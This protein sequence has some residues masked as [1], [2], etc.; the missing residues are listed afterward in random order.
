MK[1]LSFFAGAL[2]ISLSIIGGSYIIRTSPV[3][4]PQ[5]AI[6]PTS[7]PNADTKAVLTLPE[8]AAFLN[9]QEDQ[10]RIMVETEEKW[11]KESKDA[12]PDIIPFFKIREEFFFSRTALEKWAEQS[13]NEH[14]RYNRDEDVV[15]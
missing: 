1:N 2:L 11:I 13:A 10:L 3:P 6:Q 9:L 8:A 7:L 14:R 5:P 4:Q 12:F 15:K